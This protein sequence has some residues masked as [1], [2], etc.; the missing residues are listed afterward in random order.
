MPD[1]AS[2]AFHWPEMLWLLVLVPLLALY[3]LRLAVRKRRTAQ[4]YASLETVG[5]S[6]GHDSALRRYLPGA[7]LIL[8][9]C[10]ML[11]AVARPHAVVA[12]PSRME[13]VILAMDVSGSMRASD[14]K[15]SRMVAAQN[16]ARAF[17]AAQ[18]VHV[19]IGVVSIAGTAAL[20][21]S[22]TRSREDILQAIDR[23]QPQP[24][25]A[26]AS[27]LAIS[28]ATLLPSSGIDVEEIIHGSSSKRRDHSPWRAPEPSKPV[29]PGSYGS[30]AVV[31]LS[32]GQSNVGPDPLKVA[33]IAADRGVRIYTVGM[34]TSEGVTLSVEGWSMRVRLDEDILKKIATITRGEYFRADA[35]A[36]L[37]R[38]YR[39]LSARL[40][41][42]KHRTTEVTAIFAGIGAGLAML[43]A[44]LSL[45][46]FNR[47]L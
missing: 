24:G 16:A 25:T 26:L 9:L 38:I 12:L 42:E 29:A 43:A 32:D 10:A 19:R 14:L 47:I 41:I 6:T 18:P 44:L 27:G 45:L 17:I 4:L 35:A 39:E 23:F 8:G 11:L 34:G 1:L 20:A 21:Q 7:L 2:I 13:T 22:P 15:P 3:Y 33:K 37:S 36:E 5:G 28:L 31:L 40:A 30:A 46:W